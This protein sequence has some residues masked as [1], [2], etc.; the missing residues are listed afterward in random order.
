MPACAADGAF[1][2]HRLPRRQRKKEGKAAKAGKAA[3]AATT[4]MQGLPG[5]KP[6]AA[7]AAAAAAQSGAKQVAPAPVVGQALLGFKF[8]RKSIM[9]HLSFA[10]AVQ[11]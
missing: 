11:G 1:K 6:G 8:D 9:K 3:A 7:A 4:A 10:Q 5:A 2:P